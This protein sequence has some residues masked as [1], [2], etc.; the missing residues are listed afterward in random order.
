MC[1]VVLASSLVF[2]PMAIVS[3]HAQETVKIGLAVANNTFYAPIYAAQTLG[4]FKKAGLSAEIT[5]YRGGAAAQQALSVGGEDLIT[6]FAAGVGLAVKKG[7]K[8]KMIGTIDAAPNAWHLIV[9]KSAPYKNVKDLAGKKVGVSAKASTSDALALW[10]AKRAGVQFQTVPVGAAGLLP[11]LKSHQLDGVVIPPPQSLE[12]LADGTGKSL[13][14][15]GSM[16][17]TL[18]D[19]WVASETTM[20]Q[21]PEL[22]RKTLQV[23]YQALAYMRTHPKWA[24]AYLKKMTKETDNRVVKLGYEQGTLKQSADGKME[25]RW[26]ENG[27]KL[28]VSTGMSVLKGMN[29][30]LI[31]TNQFLPSSK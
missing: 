17:P 27:L 9:A 28:G 13:L 18:P 22:A 29:P 5:T 14:N 19:V 1:C 6:Y 16:E 15:Y 23:F 8:E 20:K 31:Y 26:V 7:A 24:L 4:Y 21:H 10:A 30:D 25:R 3:A 2:A 11:L 12:T